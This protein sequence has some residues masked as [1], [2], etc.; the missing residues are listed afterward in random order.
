MN[1]SV[2]PQ[3]DELEESLF[4]HLKREFKRNLILGRAYFPWTPEDNI[5]YG[6]AL[7]YGEEIK[8]V[9]LCDGEGKP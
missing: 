5:F 9:F 3:W 7:S 1:K 6:A 4:Y 8:R 2:Y